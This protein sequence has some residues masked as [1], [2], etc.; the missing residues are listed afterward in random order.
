MTSTAKP[1]GAVF[2]HELTHERAT[3]SRPTGHDWPD[4]RDHDGDGFRWPRAEDTLGL[5]VTVHVPPLPGESR[6]RD[7]PGRLTLYRYAPAGVNVMIDT[8]EDDP[9][10]DDTW[11][12]KLLD[13]DIRSVA[14][15]MAKLVTAADWPLS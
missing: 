13:V 5:D 15:W 14:T 9:D 4:Q 7:I 1:C 6:Y 2:E 8:H 11:S 12:V 10:R 3:C